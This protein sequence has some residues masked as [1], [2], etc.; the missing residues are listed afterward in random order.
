MMSAKTILLVAEN[1]FHLSLMA[2]LL[3]AN[4]LRTLRAHEPQEAL[5]MAETHQPALVVVDL[6]L[7]PGA[8]DGILAALH[9]RPATAQ[10]PVVAVAS[11]EQGGRVVG[12]PYAAC[13]EKPINTSSFPRKVLRALRSQAVERSL[14]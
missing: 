5:H 12:Q 14:P 11:Q 13:L 10:I 4:G 1:D 7:E 6:D 3:A 8:S 2:D 9:T